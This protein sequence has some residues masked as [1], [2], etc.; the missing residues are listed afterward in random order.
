MGKFIS[1]KT[2]IT[3]LEVVRSRNKVVEVFIREIQSHQYHFFFI[4]INL[5]QFISKQ[6]LVKKQVFSGKSSMWMVYIE[7][8]IVVEDYEN[9]PKHWGNV[10]C[11]ICAYGWV[12]F[13]FGW[14]LLVFV[15]FLVLSTA[16]LLHIYY[17][18]MCNRCILCIYIVYVGHKCCIWRTKHILW[19]FLYTK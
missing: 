17:V 12:L 3:V 6:I 4:Y 14:I 11:R 16:C 19:V 7:Q 5:Y 2:N 18:C 8:N 13:I 1:I 15:Q 9:T 10:L